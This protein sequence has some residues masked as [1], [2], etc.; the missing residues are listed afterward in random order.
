MNN[1]LKMIRFDYSITKGLGAKY[2]YYFAALCTVG[3]LS[4]CFPAAF[5]FVII[6]FALFSPLETIRKGDFMKIYGLLPIE[7]RY[8]TRALFAEI[9]YPQIAG[10]I[11]CELLLLITR[12]VGEARLYPSYLQE[13]IYDENKLNILANLGMRYSDLYV[14]AAIAMAA[15]TIVVL[16]F[17]MI[18]EIKGETIALMCCVPF[19]I[20]MLASALGY[21]LGNDNGAVPSISEMLPESA[22]LRVFIII[23][24][25][26]EVIAAE[27][28]FSSF[29]I[30]ATAKKEI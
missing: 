10:G 30:K 19:M 7:R 24:S 4:G 15:I 1:V 23:V 14:I 18:L 28:L 16:F 6:P 3:C 17:Y 20:A 22:I 9:A 5:G 2:A 25:F 21:M 27:R 26:A 8:V 13:H 29:T 11:V 12:A